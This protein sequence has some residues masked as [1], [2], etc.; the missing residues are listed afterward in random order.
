MGVQYCLH[1]AN[2]INIIFL[3][4]RPKWQ[5]LAPAWDEDSQGKN[6]I[7]VTESHGFQYQSQNHMVFISNQAPIA[8]DRC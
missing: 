2:F 5:I 4:L 8:K 3:E 1:T 6:S 7:S